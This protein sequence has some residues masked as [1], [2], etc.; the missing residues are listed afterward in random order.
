MDNSMLGQNLLHAWRHLRRKPS[1][2]AVVVATLALGIGANTAIFSLV[3]G[4]LLRP[5]PYKDPSQLVRLRTLSTRRGQAGVDISIPDLYDYR[6]AN[7]TF[8]DMGIF[9]ERNI[10]VLDGNAAQ[11]VN[12]ALTTPGAFNALG[13]TPFMGRTFVEQEDRS[14][15]DVY[16]AVLSYELWQARYGGEKNILGRQIRTPMASYTVIGIMPPGQ[17]YPGRA[18][19]WIPL[20]SYV[21]NSNKDWITLRG[22]RMY[23]A[24]GRVRLGVT[25]EQAQADLDSISDRL[26]HDYP[27]TNKEF[28]L[29]LQSLRDAE[30]GTIRP[31]LLLL[32]G[33]TVLVLIICAA[34]IANL[35]LAVAADRA[36]ESVIRTALGASVL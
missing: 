3:Y 21:K 10:D 4:L 19:M 8:A 15:G 32:L 24:I 36:R 6:G 25:T 22:S 20:Q 31:Y 11:S 30:V 2:C 14:G 16:K 28:R 29:G 1:F 23:S 17:G 27:N 26:A 9:A 18:E 35:S 7:R 12:V 5:F 13:V 34:N 33:A